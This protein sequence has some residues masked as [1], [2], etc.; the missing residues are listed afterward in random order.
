MQRRRVTQRRSGTRGAEAETTQTQAVAVSTARL[1]TVVI[2]LQLLRHCVRQSSTLA[3]GISITA[4]SSG[5]TVV[6]A[7]NTLSR[8]S[9][10]S[11]SASRSNASSRCQ[12]LRSASGLPAPRA[13]TSSTAVQ[14]VR[15]V[16]RAA[17]RTCNPATGAASRR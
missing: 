4:I 5:F 8:P 14:S 12:G 9:T 1:L 16:V 17:D 2:R 13:G 15:G 3:W 6:L 7:C 10:P 11:Y